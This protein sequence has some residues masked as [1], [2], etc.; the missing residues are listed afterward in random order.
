MYS[1][2][3]IATLA[4]RVLRDSKIRMRK[5]EVVD[6]YAVAAAYQ[7]D[8][9]HEKLDAEI[10]GVL[11]IDDQ[12]DAIILV[13]AAHSNNRQRFTVA[14][15]LGHYFMHKSPGIHVDKVFMRDAKSS[16]GMHFIE[17]EANRFASEI[18]M[19]RDLIEKDLSN[20]HTLLSFMDTEEQIATLA[21]KYG[22]STL[23]MSIKL[24]DLGYISAADFAL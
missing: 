10:S 8:V 22:V 18:L 13:N 5:T 19:P 16:Q 4:A 14:H 9:R 23:A 1:R 12:G 11:K 20:R 21:K 3:K 15:E 7:V 17:V 24:Q 6:I 2:A